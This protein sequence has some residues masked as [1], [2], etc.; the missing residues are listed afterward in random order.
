M[1]DVMVLQLGRDAAMMML[2]VAGP[3][4]GVGL[5]VGLAISI[6]QAAT[7]VREMTLTVVPKVVA[8]GLVLAVLGP[9]MLAQMLRYLANVLNSLPALA[10]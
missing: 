3:L 7:Q 6:F 2:K 1:T 8:I 5:A 10:R 4:L 9:W